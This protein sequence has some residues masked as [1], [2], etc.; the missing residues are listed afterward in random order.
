[1]GSG[2]VGKY[3]IAGMASAM[4]EVERCMGRAA[5]D[6]AHALRRKQA[7]DGLPSWSNVKSPSTTLVERGSGA[8]LEPTEIYKRV[9][10]SVYIVEA[11][12]DLET[13]AN[14]RFCSCSL[15]QHRAYELPCD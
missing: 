1:M 9:A 4:D 14:C 3:D 10:A 5:E 8:E 11:G 2:Q 15:G 7:I 13:I 6:R 12:A